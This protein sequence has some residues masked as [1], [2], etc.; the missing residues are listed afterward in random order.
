MEISNLGQFFILQSFHKF[1]IFESFIQESFILQEY[2]KDQNFERTRLR[3]YKRYEYQI[4]QGR[5]ECSEG[6]PISVKFF[7]KFIFCQELIFF[8][9]TILGCKEWKNKYEKTSKNG[10]F[11]KKRVKKHVFCRIGIIKMLKNAWKIQI[12]VKS[13]N[14]RFFKNFGFSI[15]LYKNTRRP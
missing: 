13:L 9:I 10:Q 14:F 2:T 11:S 8:E 5:W 4:L 1:W 7:Q 3:N 15:L 12:W 6:W